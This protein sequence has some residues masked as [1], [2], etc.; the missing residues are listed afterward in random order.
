MAEASL[1]AGR[2]PAAQHRISASGA[3]PSPPPSAELLR[4]FHNFIA[5]LSGAAAPSNLPDTVAVASASLKPVPAA[6]AKDVSREAY[7]QPSPLAVHPAPTA[8]A[9]PSAGAPKPSTPSAA[10]PS[11]AP[12]EST[13]PTRPSTPAPKA[14]N[15]G[16]QS[17]LEAGADVEMIG[18]A[19][20]ADAPPEEVDYASFRGVLNEGLSG[21]VTPLIGAQ[22]PGRPTRG[23]MM[24]KVELPRSN[25]SGHSSLKRRRIL[26]E[27]KTAAAST[28]VSIV[29]VSSRSPQASASSPSTAANPPVTLSARG[30]ERRA[31]ARKADESIHK[32]VESHSSSN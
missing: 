11:T 23:K 32:A 18:D 9:D 24:P 20:G 3:P 6:T 15:A 28:P 27:S 19:G 13:G 14:S 17:N 29:R 10:P 22:P 31:A 7:K 2:D 8:P 16:A 21:L 25:P 26:A 1:L 30:T 4:A 12:A 5:T